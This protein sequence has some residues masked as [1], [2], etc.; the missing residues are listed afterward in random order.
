MRLVARRIG[1]CLGMALLVSS[2]VSCATEQDFGPG[3]GELSPEAQEMV[4]LS[5]GSMQGVFA[6]PESNVTVQFTSKSFRS[7]VTTVDAS[8]NRRKISV[9]VDAYG[10][11][12]ELSGNAANMT[13][14]ERQGLATAATQLM[15]QMDTNA[16][17]DYE[18]KSAIKEAA[19]ALVGM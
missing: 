2:L 13:E 5:D 8:F 18:Q 16:E 7:G 12:R 15:D 3:E 9:V 19:A 4:T 11:V 1:T 6:D 10:R 17:V 14:Q